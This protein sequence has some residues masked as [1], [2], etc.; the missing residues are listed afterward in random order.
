M[1]DFGDPVLTGVVGLMLAS[2]LSRWVLSIALRNYSIVDRLWSLLPVF[3]VWYFVFAGLFELRAAS[4]L[5]RE[6]SLAAFL[7]LHPRLT[8]MALLAAL[9]GCRLTYN[10]ARKGGYARHAEDYRWVF[11]RAEINNEVLYQLL[12]FVF[13]AFVQNVLLF[14]LAFPA[15]YALRSPTHAA[16]AVSTA[17]AAS[18]ADT[19]AL[20]AVWSL[21]TLFVGGLT[22]SDGVAAVCF[23]TCFAIETAADEQQWRFYRYR[24]LYRTALALTLTSHLP[25]SPNKASTP[26]DSHNGASSSNNNNNRSGAAAAADDAADA[27]DIDNADAAVVVNAL[28]ARAIAAAAARSGVASLEDLRHG[29]CTSSLFAHSRHP[30]FAAEVSL[31]WSFALFAVLPSIASALF[32][33]SSSSSSFVSSLSYPLDVVVSQAAA[34]LPH[35]VAQSPL[36]T[37]N[38]NASGV[39]AVLAVLLPLAGACGLTLLFNA[40]TNLTERITLSKYPT[41]S[42]YQA[43]VPRLLPFPLA[44]EVQYDAPATLPLSFPVPL[45][46][47]QE[48]QQQ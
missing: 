4:L 32:S 3:Y 8:A 43:A 1:L 48:P 45:P 46:L 11:V 7:A 12:N 18:A 9:W 38:G 16:A 15:Y 17:L 24:D 34:V 26:A 20:S 42:K 2:A 25:A 39:N 35:L 6:L 5:T 30:N 29:Y 37:F 40:S 27:I 22:F 19:S 33:S 21:F 28:S 47:Q 10:Y 44:R 41:Y 31:W 14:L 13:T 23:L 36:L